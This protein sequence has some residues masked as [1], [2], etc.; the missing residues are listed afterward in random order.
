MK[1]VKTGVTAL[2]LVVA[3][4]AFADKKVQV[5]P[6]YISHGIN[7]YNGELI[8]DYSNTS[9]GV[10]WLFEAPREIGVFIEG[11]P[12]GTDGGVITAD[13]DRS[14]PVATTRD[15]LDFFNPGGEIDL[16]LLNVPL[17]QIGSNFFGFT[18]VDDRIVPPSFETISGN[19]TVYRS[20]GVNEAPTVAEWEAARGV[21]TAVVNDDGTTT[22]RVTLRDAFPNAVFTLWDV[23]S[24]FPLSENEAGYAVPLGGIPNVV[25]TDA[26]GCVFREVILPYDLT[27]E[28]KSGAESCTSYV[29]GFYHFDGQAYGASPAGTFANAP[30]GLYA[31]NQ[32]VWPINGDLL[33]APATEFGRPVHGC[34]TPYRS[35]FAG[36]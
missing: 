17:D 24:N 1:F 2:S 27:R 23:G 11:A 3:S 9:P 28:C 14:L 15:F 5:F 4:A 13:T 10:E 34:K 32:M 6:G 22:V 7:V 12:E 33:Q 16:S 25:R 29:A 20:A 21:L 35:I 30:A 36:K 8:A 19:P 18:A 26:E 31:G